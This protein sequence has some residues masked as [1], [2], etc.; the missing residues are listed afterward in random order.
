MNLDVGNKVGIVLLTQD[1]HVLFKLAAGMP[2]MS[3][4]TKV[5]KSVFMFA[6]PCRAAKAIPCTELILSDN[7]TIIYKI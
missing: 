1:D 3:G 5:L 2:P 7:L 6:A 4:D